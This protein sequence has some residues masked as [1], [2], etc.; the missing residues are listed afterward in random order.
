[1]LETTSNLTSQDVE[2]VTGVMNKV[3]RT[4]FDT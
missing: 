2:N 4:V 1:M 3:F